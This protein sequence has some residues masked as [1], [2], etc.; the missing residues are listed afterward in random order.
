M[1][2]PARPG[3]KGRFAPRR[4]AKRRG[5]AGP[6][7]APGRV[8][9]AGRSPG[10]G[11]GR[12]LARFLW[13]GLLGVCCG[14][15]SFLL[16]AFGVFGGPFRSV[17][18]RPLGGCGPGRFLPPLVARLFRF[19]GGRA[20]FL[21]RRCGSVFGVVGWPVRAFWRSGC[22]LRRSLGSRWRWRCAV[23]GGVRSGGPAACSGRSWAR[24]AR[25]GGRVR[26]SLR[27]RWR[28]V[29]LGLLSVFAAGLPAACRARPA[30]GLAGVLFVAC[31]SR[32]AAGAACRRAAWFGLRV[33]ACGARGAGWLVAVA[34]PLAPRPCPLSLRLGVFVPGGAPALPGL[35]LPVPRRGGASRPAPAPRA[36][37]PVSLPL[38]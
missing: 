36:P 9:S 10:V 7:L 37:R 15:V 30:A 23:L 32:L 35:P 12:F 2:R 17:R 34:L 14:S 18:V 38:F 3:D 21:V 28:L 16:C 24:F 33:L 13:S 31:P 27:R 26:R 19:R 4:P 25:P 6:P 20:V 11:S 1:C 8:G 5:A 29:V 22:L